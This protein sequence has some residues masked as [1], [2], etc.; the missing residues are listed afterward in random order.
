M[1]VCVCVRVSICV[2]CYASLLI[3]SFLSRIRIR[4]GS[5]I[6]VRQNS[7]ASRA[8]RVAQRAQFH[9]A[10]G[11]QLLQILRPHLTFLPAFRS[12]RSRR[13]T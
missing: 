5:R 2:A 4:T 6:G 13:R 11:A 1:R 8:V 12:L 7:F 10:E 9:H 3:L